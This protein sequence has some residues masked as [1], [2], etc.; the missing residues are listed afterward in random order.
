M[1]NGSGPGVPEL[2]VKSC[3]S[4]GTDDAVAY[5]DEAGDPEEYVV[6]AL[7]DGDVAGLLDKTGRSRKG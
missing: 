1:V 5:P 4:K 6:F 2:R 7:E 3:Y